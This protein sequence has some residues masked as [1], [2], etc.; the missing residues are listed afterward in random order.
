MVKR[1]TVAFVVLVLFAQAPALLGQKEPSQK[2]RIWVYV[3]PGRYLI[4]VDVWLHTSEEPL[5]VPYCGEQESGREDLCAAAAWLER[6]SR[7]GWRKAE[8]RNATMGP[9][10]D[11]RKAE[12]VLIPSRSKRVFSFSFNTD[13]FGIPP[14][15]RLR[16]VVD[17]WPD[18]KSLRE[19]VP[20][21]Q[22]TS[23]EFVWPP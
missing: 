7:D 2:P 5:F 6:Q 4:E 3:P 23:P 12:G 17:A 21:V 11:P 8:V 16:V 18:E 13:V 20:P 22:V 9:G 1:G 14:G 10:R 19:G 15:T